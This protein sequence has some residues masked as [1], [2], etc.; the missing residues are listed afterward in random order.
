M[1]EKESK[2]GRPKSPFK[3]RDTRVSGYVTKED[4][5]Y[6]SEVADNFGF[7]ST[8]E[9]VTAILEELCKGGFSAFAFMRLGWHVANLPTKRKRTG[10]HLDLRPP[11]PL[12]GR[13]PDLEELAD[14]VEEVKR[15][16]QEGNS[17]EL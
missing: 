16:I 5:E 12:F 11:T 13:T 4:A 2:R 8:S 10:Y 6:V 9:F 1:S 17:N 7:S 14:H 15:K 3:K